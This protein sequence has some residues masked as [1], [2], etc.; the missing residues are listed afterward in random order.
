MTSL[1][2][3]FRSNADYLIRCSMIWQ[4]RNDASLNRGGT[5]IVRGG[6]GDE[7]E[8]LPAHGLNSSVECETVGEW[9]TISRSFDEDLLN[10]Q[11]ALTTV[12]LFV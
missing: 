3:N 11:H 12:G 2:G 6:Q 7:G 1:V 8:E 10:L 4:E 5:E 9:T